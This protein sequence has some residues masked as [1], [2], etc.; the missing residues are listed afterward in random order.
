MRR[1]RNEREDERIDNRE[2]RENKDRRR[3][4]ERTI[5]ARNRTMITAF[6]LF[7]RRTRKE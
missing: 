2:N 5:A 6:C 7:K 3:G 4:E 1:G